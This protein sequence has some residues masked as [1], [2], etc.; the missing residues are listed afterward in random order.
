YAEMIDEIIAQGARETFA[1]FV[2]LLLGCAL[3]IS[4]VFFILRAVGLYRI[5]RR[6]GNKGAALAFVPG[7]SGY[8]FGAAADGLRKRKPSNY[9][10]HMLMVG[11]LYIASTAVFYYH[12]IGRFLLLYETLRTGTDVSTLTLLEETMMVSRGDT[13][14]YL[15]YQ[16]SRLAGY[17]FTFVTMLGYL[18]I[19]QLFRSRGAFFLFFSSLFIPEVM[20][21]HLFVARNAELYPNPPVF[22]IPGMNDEGFP[23]GYPNDSENGEGPINPDDPDA[24]TE[25]HHPW[26]D[27][28]DAPEDGGNDRASDNDEDSTEEGPKDIPEDTPEDTPSSASDEDDGTNA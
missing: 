21:I 27:E 22:H 11:L 9:C 7:L 28:D 4:A 8:A 10:I 1:Q 25:V 20:S 2:V 19:L 3:V 18:R 13:A 12:V 24:Y 5:N 15:S 26:D 14:F 17:V 16:I 6:L 23:G